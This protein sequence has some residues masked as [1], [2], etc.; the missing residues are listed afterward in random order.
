MAA[1]LESKARQYGS[2]SSRIWKLVAYLGRYGHQ[3]A[4]VSLSLPVDQLMALVKEVGE[5]LEKEAEA[6]KPKR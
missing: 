5:L 2:L 1:A 4:N 6:A 3:P